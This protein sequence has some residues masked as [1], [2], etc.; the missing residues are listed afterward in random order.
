M[1]DLKTL[2]QT[3]DL[4]PIGL[5][6]ADNSIR[7]YCT[8]VDADIFAC[9]GV[10]GIHYCTIPAYGDMVFCVDPS[11]CH[12]PEVFPIAESMEYLVR[13]LLACGETSILVDADSVCD[14][15]EFQTNVETA[16]MEE[17][18]Q[19]TL[20]LLK[21]ATGLEPVLN[22]Y[23]PLLLLREGLD[24]SHIQFSE[25]Y[26]ELHQESAPA[27]EKLEAEASPD[28]D[29]IP[30]HIEG[31]VFECHKPGAVF[32]VRHPL[33]GTLHTIRVTDCHAE[34]VECPSFYDIEMPSH[35]YLLT[36]TMEPEL[37][38]GSWSLRPLQEGDTVR[39]P[40]LPDAKNAANI[41]II[42]GADGPTA[43][44]VSAASSHD[45]IGRVFPSSLHF[46]LPEEMQWQLVWDFS[47]NEEGLFPNQ[48]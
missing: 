12:E 40:F 39:F 1:S 6:P 48:K 29:D 36:C 18:V 46:T 35:L 47:P 25:E 13:D 8:P 20:A 2:L 19:A 14:E 11:G 44:F 16:L 28:T 15:K 33:T 45:E 38:I 34:Q 7:Y 41:G 31:P 5:E 26:M 37:E 23:E 27:D 9:A 22:L 43:I 4:S 21:E 17:D 42:G 30:I 32:E 24:Y 3:L 10:D